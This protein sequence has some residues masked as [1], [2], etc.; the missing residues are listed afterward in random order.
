MSLHSALRAQLGIAVPAMSIAK[1][2]NVDPEPC[3]LF[4]GIVDFLQVRISCNLLLGSLALTAEAALSLRI[5]DGT[6]G[7]H[8]RTLE[9]AREW[10]QSAVPGLKFAHACTVA[11]LASCSLSCITQHHSETGY[12][13]AVWG[14]IW[15]DV[16]LLCSNTTFGRRASMCSRAW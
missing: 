6:A 14:R 3:L 12:G 16:Y 8:P 4:F 5:H 2:T 9:F 10:S 7:V 13:G 1:E 11:T 15:S